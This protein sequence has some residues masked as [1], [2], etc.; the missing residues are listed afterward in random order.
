M[1]TSTF[2]NMLSF[3]SSALSAVLIVVPFALALNHIFVTVQILFPFVVITIISW[4]LS[5]CA[6]DVDMAKTG[7]ENL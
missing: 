2:I 5:L 3:I 6:I 1:K 7:G 4:V